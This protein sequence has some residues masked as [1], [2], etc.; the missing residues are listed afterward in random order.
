MSDRFSA[1]TETLIADGIVDLPAHSRKYILIQEVV[2]AIDR[3]VQSAHP[4]EWKIEDAVHKGLSILA[5]IWEATTPKKGPDN[6]TLVWCHREDVYAASAEGVDSDYRWSIDE[7]VLSS[8]CSD[9][10]SEPWAQCPQLERM[11]VDALIYSATLRLGDDAAFELDSSVSKWFGG[12]SRGNVVSIT[13]KALIWGAIKSALWASVAL[14]IGVA[15]AIT[16][17]WWLGMLAGFGFWAL[18]R[19]S[20]QNAIV[21]G[22]SEKAHVHSDMFAVYALMGQQLLSPAFLRDRLLTVANKGVTWPDGVISIVEHAALRNRVRW[23]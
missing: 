21:G 23:T 15:A 5:R 19:I 18:I 12:G 3:W 17:E 9:Y 2:A 20:Q 10:L 13:K 7:S 14:S 1:R 6:S 11:F 4:D 8:A 16:Y 22:I